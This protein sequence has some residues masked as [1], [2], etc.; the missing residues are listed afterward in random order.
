MTANQE[1]SQLQSCTCQ[2]RAAAAFKL[3]LLALVL[4]AGDNQAAVEGF[5][6]PG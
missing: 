4:G 2:V 1:M 5:E 3:G 6:L